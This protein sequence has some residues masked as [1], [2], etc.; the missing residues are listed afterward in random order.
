MTT[1]QTGHCTLFI[2]KIS[3]LPSSVNTGQFTETI[4]WT[5][6]SATGIKGDNNNQHDIIWIYPIT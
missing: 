3:E 1:A 6:L 4:I 5:I 2:Q